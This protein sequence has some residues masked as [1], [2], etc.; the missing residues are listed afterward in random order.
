MYLEEQNLEL[1]DLPEDLREMVEALKHGSNTIECNVKDALE[2]ASDVDDFRARV[3]CEI[4]SLIGEAQEIKDIVC[5][6]KVHV[7]IHLFQGILH[8]VGVHKNND[9]ARKDYE[10]RIIKAYGNLVDEQHGDD[11]I[12]MMEAELIE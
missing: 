4:D 5:K 8:E 11:E 3:S 2:M 1:D 9:E 12:M 7:V 10:A 6:E